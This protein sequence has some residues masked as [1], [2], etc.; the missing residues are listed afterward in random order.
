ML[1]L[2]QLAGF[3][4]GGDTGFAYVD[5]VSGDWGTI[6]AQDSA[7]TGTLTLNT[8]SDGGGIA[9][10]VTLTGDFSIRCTGDGSGS[11]YM[12]AFGVAD[13]ADAV[14]DMNVS[15]GDGR[16]NAEQVSPGTSYYFW[17]AGS[18]DAGGIYEKGTELFDVAVG[19]GDKLQ[20]D[21]IGDSV[22]FYINDV[23]KHTKTSAS[24]NDMFAFFGHPNGPPVDSGA[25]EVQYSA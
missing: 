25:T 19:D 15:A 4:A 9:D 10:G 3:G 23:L 12:F 14:S 22:Y 1:V 8:G 5:F 20:I 13:A 24:T 11:T 2:S 6:D 21:R 18:G 17:G 16:A 7:G